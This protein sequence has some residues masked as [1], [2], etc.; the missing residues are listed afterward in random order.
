MGISDWVFPGRKRRR[1]LLGLSID[2]VADVARS[3][4]KIER[5]DDKT[6][7]LWRLLC[8]ASRETIG[9]LLIQNHD[10]QMDWGLKKHI[11]LVDD[12]TLVVMF[13]W[14]LLYQIVVFKNRGLD[15]YEPDSQVGRLHDVARRF[16]ETEFIRLGIATQPPGPWASNWDRLV[17]LESAME[18][19]NQTYDLLGLRNDITQRIN[20]VSHFTTITE[21]AYDRLVSNAPADRDGHG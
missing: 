3:R 16:V 15:G 13:W 20:H 9:Q 6:S 19:Y 8:D 17:A 10:K 12:P 7:R 4:A 1:N 18:F 14:M 21:R 2:G 5:L 11:K